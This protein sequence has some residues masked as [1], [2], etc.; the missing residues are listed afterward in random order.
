MNKVNQLAEKYVKLSLKIGQHS[1]YYVDAYY[2]PEEWHPQDV[3]TPLEQLKEEALALYKSS[4]QLTNEE[5]ATQQT[6]LEFL[7]IHFSSSIQYINQ[8]Q[9]K[10]LNFMSECKAL[11]DIQPPEYDE[12]HFNTVLA[13]L[14]SL[15]PG[16]GELNARF[17]N[18]RSEFIIPVNKLSQVFDAAIE[19][20]RS[21]TLKHTNLPANENFNV[22][23][24]NN[25]VWSAYNWYK[26]N[27]YSLIQLNTDFPVYIERAIDLAAHEGYPGHHIFNAQMEKYL[28][29]DKGW[30]EYSI[31]NLYSPLS[32]LAEGS[33][34]Y[35]IHVAFPW[36]ERV[37]FERD[38]LFPLAGINPNKS[39]LYYKIQTVLHQLSY[40]DNMV[41]CRYINNEIDSEQA[42]RLLMKYALSSEERSRQRLA[43]IKHNRSYVITYNYGQDL[44]KDYL[45]NQVNNQS[46]DEL[47]RVFL[48]LLANPK[49]G[50]MMQKDIK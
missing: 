22:E 12:E 43:F 25:Q 11:Y 46:H 6:R 8:L 27:S 2:G 40:V 15:V 20:A 16:T 28:V 19:E 33:A 13:E 36:Q 4:E 38:I 41:A 34:N 10:H 23:L 48:E 7:R 26:G 9:G 18:Y 49:T 50:S 1:K 30:M 32:L 44:V 39:E 47:W 24:V 21:R 35:G 3:K 42:I 17:N 5:I 29:N 45:A 31:Y 37:E 14:D